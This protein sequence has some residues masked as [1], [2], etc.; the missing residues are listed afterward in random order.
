MILPRHILCLDQEDRALCRGEF[1]H[2]NPELLH[3]RLLPLNTTALSSSPIKTQKQIRISLSPLKINE[4]DRKGPLSLWP[5]KLGSY[6]ERNNQKSIPALGREPGLQRLAGAEVL[7]PPGCL[8]LASWRQHHYYISPL[9]TAKTILVWWTKKAFKS[10]QCRLKALQAVNCFKRKNTQL[11]N[12]TWKSHQLAGCMLHHLSCYLEPEKLS[13][14]TAFPRTITSL[15][16][17]MN[18]TPLPLCEACCSTNY[19][20]PSHF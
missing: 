15:N 4:C 8:Q 16:P 20:P 2:G 7:L 17:P 11:E 10:E 1:R 19:S 9:F 14:R 13:I 5:Q 18:Y 12:G 3:L 6:R